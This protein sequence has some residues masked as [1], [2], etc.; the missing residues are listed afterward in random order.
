MVGTRSEHPRRLVGYIQQQPYGGTILHL[1]LWQ[2]SL[3]ICI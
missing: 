2:S 3:Q 1:L